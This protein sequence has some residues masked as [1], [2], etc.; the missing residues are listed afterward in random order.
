MAYSNTNA[1]LR[2]DLNGV[3]EE[4]FGGDDFFIA[5]KALPPL[6]VNSK[7]GQ[8]PKF[9]I[10]AAAL[11]SDLATTREPGGNYGRVNR[12]YV[13][14]NY[15]CVDRGLEEVVDDAYAADVDRFYDAEEAAARMTLRNVLIGYE[16][17]VAALLI[18][19]STFTATEGI[20]GTDGDYTQAQIAD[21]DFPQDVLAAIN[22]LNLKGVQPNTIIMSSAVWTRV[23]AS[24]KFQNWMRGS[25]PT[26]SVLNITPAGAANSFAENGITQVLVGRAAKNTVVQGGTASSATIWPN[27]HIFVGKV[28]TGSMF[29]GGVGR[30][31]VWNDEGGLFVTETYR[32]EQRRSDIVRVR[33]NTDEKVVDA[34]SGE[35]IITDY[36]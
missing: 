15:L 17:R 23:S 36:A 28:T 11:Q 19:A 9:Q 29:D 27:T 24:T 32:E 30:T 1:V 10:G 22:R 18:N 16:I 25:R 8:Y 3:V 6:M 20:G 5:D 14:D 4:A 2:A 34:N 13:N 31:M 7:T 33:Q 26:D 21:F 12:E 35:L